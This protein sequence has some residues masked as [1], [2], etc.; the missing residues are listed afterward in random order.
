MTS[1]HKS[2]KGGR[3]I[4]DYEPV[5][6]DLNDQHFVC[7]PALQGAKLLEFVAKADGDSGGEAAGALYGLFEDVMVPEEYARFKA[8]L[9]QPDLIIEMDTIAEIAAWLIEE[10]TSRPTQR[11]ESS[12]PGPSSAGPTSMELPS[13]AA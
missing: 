2:F 10:Y 9:D 13:S 3:A 8:Y 6:F 7:K 4:G 11:S 1:R 12:A 5:E